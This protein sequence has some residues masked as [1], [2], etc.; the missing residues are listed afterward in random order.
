MNSSLSR[1]KKPNIFFVCD[2]PLVGDGT[3]NGARI[4]DNARKQHR[5]SNQRM[6]KGPRLSG[7]RRTQLERNPIVENFY[8]PLAAAAPDA[9]EGNV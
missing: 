2:P 7:S 1:K 9:K 8:T 3:N 4:F 6:I 5:G